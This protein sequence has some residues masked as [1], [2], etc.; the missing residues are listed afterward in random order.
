[1][2]F[3][4]TLEGAKIPWLS[5][6][7]IEYTLLKHR[8][9]EIVEASKDLP[10]ARTPGW[11]T[12]FGAHDAASLM[13][14]WITL[15]DFELEKVNSFTSSKL[16]DLKLTVSS[17]S[18]RISQMNDS[19]PAVLLAELDAVSVLIVDLEGFIR[20]FACVV[21]STLRGTGPQSGSST[22]IGSPPGTYLGAMR[23]SRR[24]SHS[25][26]L[27]HTRCMITLFMSVGINGTAVLKIA[28]K[29]DRM[30]GQ[31][32]M[33]WVSARLKHQKFYN[34]KLD[35]FIC[36]LSDMYAHIRTLN[37]ELFFGAG[38]T[39]V[40]SSTDATGG[41]LWQAPEI[42]ER[43]TSKY[44]VRIEDVTRL[45][46]AIIRFLPVLVYG[47]DTSEYRA[48]EPLETVSACTRSMHMHLFT[49]LAYMRT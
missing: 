4:K 31:Q 39:G 2:H 25:P 37:P 44:W 6:G 8:L 22:L 5:S 36:A 12:R 7:Y 23:I 27:N 17:L 43:T 16:D 28:K 10:V 32:S 47:R 26:A 49:P 20:K 21:G 46:I 13:I 33:P 3:A 9:R 18:R 35:G 38:S 14:D 40:P 29:Y 19:Q 11:G 48:V 24:F 34:Q 15:F 42:F 41:G 45:K 1:M 30:L